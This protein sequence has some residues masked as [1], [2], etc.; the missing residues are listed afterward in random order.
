M[1]AP[2][3]LLSKRGPRIE[4]AFRLLLRAVSGH[5]LGLSWLATATAIG[6]DAAT[7]REPRRVAASQDGGRRGAGDRL[8]RQR[9]R[10]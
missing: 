1:S 7:A 8:A 2:L 5:D 4:Q 10:L 6:T 3:L 9:N